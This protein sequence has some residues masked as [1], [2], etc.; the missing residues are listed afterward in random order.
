MQRLHILRF[1]SNGCFNNCLPVFQV[2]V[3]VIE[4][5]SVYLAV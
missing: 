1:F 3:Q 2:E 4:M 5:F